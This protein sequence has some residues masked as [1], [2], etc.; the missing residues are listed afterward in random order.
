MKHLRILRFAAVIWISSVSVNLTADISVQS[1]QKDVSGVTI[2]LQTGLLRLEVCDERTIHVICTPANKFPEKKKF[3]V[4]RQ[5]TPVPFEWHERPDKDGF[6][7]GDLIQSVGGTA[8]KTV[9]Q[10]IECLCNAPAEKEIEI[11]IIR[12]QQPATIIVGGWPE[13]PEIVLL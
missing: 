12:M 9:E 4:N 8:V 2:K 5:W 13:P 3:V 6:I 11:G 10:M 7:L 1:T